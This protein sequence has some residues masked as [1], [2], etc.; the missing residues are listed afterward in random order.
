MYVVSHIS[1]EVASVLLR[2]VVLKM[3]DPKVFI[4]I[5]QN[6]KRPNPKRPINVLSFKTSL[7]MTTNTCILYYLYL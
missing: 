5:R 7:V 3:V 6:P 1:A 4:G 2:P